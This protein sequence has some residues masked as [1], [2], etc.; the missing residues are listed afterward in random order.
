MWLGIVWYG[1]HDRNRLFSLECSREFEVNLINV[2]FL[3]TSEPSGDK[4]EVPNFG[5]KKNSG[6]YWENGL[7]MIET[8]QLN[9][10]NSSLLPLMQ[11][12]TLSKDH[13][14]VY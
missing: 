4:A 9:W 10:L 12:A 7:V 1:K 13:E 11:A 6:W 14:F 2:L 8:G 3:S 5:P